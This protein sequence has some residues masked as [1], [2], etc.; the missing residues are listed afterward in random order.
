MW[1]KK[2][3]AKHY[4][5]GV[6]LTQLIKQ[7]PTD[8]AAEQWFIASR[9]PDGVCCPKCGSDNVQ[10]RKSRKPQPYRCRA[11]RKDFSVKTGTLMQGS[12]L[13]L[14]DLGA[15]FLP[16]D[17]WPQGHLQHEAA[18]RLGHHAK[19]SVAPRPPYPRDV[20]V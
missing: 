3:L 18:P 14:S 16:D 12:N 6:T 13:G 19:V 5:N 1:H 8:E 4:R 20:A 9:W 7:F 15:G 10:E 11:C 17:D 2:H